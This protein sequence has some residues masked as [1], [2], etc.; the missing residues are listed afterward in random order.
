MSDPVGPRSVVRP[1]YLG[2]MSSLPEVSQPFFS[3]F[4][5]TG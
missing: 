5:R 2:S 3:N 4:T 1:R